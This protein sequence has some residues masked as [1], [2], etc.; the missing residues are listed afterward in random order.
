LL[1]RAPN[2][3]GTWFNLG[4]F[5]LEHRHGDRAAAA[6]QRAVGADPSYGEAWRWLGA[7]LIDSDR[8]AAIDAW[9][10]AERLQ[11]GDYDLLFN[12][13]MVMAESDRPAGA[14]PYL[15]RFVRE[16]P[17]ERYGRDIPQ[18]EAAINRAGRQPFRPER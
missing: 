6:F 8:A 3:A 5:E 4:M 1:R 12:L 13:G 7:A 2:A 18:V 15:Q 16:A 11:P 10:H 9:Q 17:R 14:L